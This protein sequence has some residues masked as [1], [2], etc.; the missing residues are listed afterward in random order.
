MENKPVLFRFH[1]GLLEDSLK[2]VIEIH[3]FEQLLLHIVSEMDME[4][5]SISYEPYV[6][7]E[8]IGWDTQIVT[9]HFKG[10]PV[11]VP[12]GFLNKQPTWREEFLNEVSKNSS[13]DRDSN[14]VDS[15]QPSASGLSGCD[16]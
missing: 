5:S 12:I 11:N 16:C 1:R 13:S 4:L 3:S 10:F 15:V 9:G 14:S 8:R 6:Y 2:T 7:D